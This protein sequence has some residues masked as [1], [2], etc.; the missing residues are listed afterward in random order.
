MALTKRAFSSESI[1]YVPG[2]IVTEFSIKDLT[3]RFF[4]LSEITPISGSGISPLF[5]IINFKTDMEEKNTSL[6]ITAKYLIKL[7]LGKIIHSSLSKKN[8]LST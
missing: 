7:K 4:I 8:F 3:C 6:T 1:T 5:F 2:V